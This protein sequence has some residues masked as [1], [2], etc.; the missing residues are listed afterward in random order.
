MDLKE[1]YGTCSAEEIKETIYNYIN[2][3]LGYQAKYSYEEYIEELQ[4]C[5]QCG[6][7]N[8][9]DSMTYH[10][11]DIGQVEELIC[12]SCRNDE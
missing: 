4:R 5:S 3:P 12:E 9:K 6:E 2:K 8:E 10:K 11:W 7:V 1:L